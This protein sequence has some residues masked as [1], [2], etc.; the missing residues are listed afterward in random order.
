MPEIAVR[1]CAELIHYRRRATPKLVEGPLEKSE[2]ESRAGEG[3]LPSTPPAPV[4][5][6]VPATAPPGR[7]AAHGLGV[8]EKNR[9]DGGGIRRED[10]RW[11]Q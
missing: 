11:P 10:K 3:Q 5:A 4:P 8:R 9:L 2:F 1:I 6:L 7:R